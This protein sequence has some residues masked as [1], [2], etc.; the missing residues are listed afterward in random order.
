MREGYSSHYF[1]YQSF[2]QSSF[3]IF[4]L[5]KEKKQILLTKVSLYGHAQ[6]FSAIQFT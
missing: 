2:V 1:V 6:H 3:S 5:T 4:G